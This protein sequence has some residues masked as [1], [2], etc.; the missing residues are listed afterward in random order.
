MGRSLQKPKSHYPDDSP[1][2]IIGLGRS[3]PLFIFALFAAFCG[4]SS[5]AEKPV[6][7]E[8]YTRWTSSRVVGTPDPLPGYQ[9]RRVFPLVEFDEPTGL[10]FYE[11]PG[12][13]AGKEWAFIT[14][15]A[16]QV[17]CM[18]N[19]AGVDRAHLFI[20]LDPTDRPERSWGLPVLAFAVAFDPAFASNRFVYLSYNTKAGLPKAVNRVSR[21]KLREL[22]P[23]RIEREDE[24][25]ILEWHTDG[26][27]GCDLK[28]GPDGM[29]YISSGDGTSTVDE[30]NTGQDASD[31]LSGIL[32]IDV[33]R[34]EDGKRYAVPKDNPFVGLP[35]VR[36]ELWAYGV[37]N[38]WKMSFDRKTGDLWVGDNGQDLWE[39]AYRIEKG[40]N[41][42]WSVF[43]GGHPHRPA[44]KIGGPTPRWTLPTIVQPHTEM[45]S[46]TGG[47]VY[48]GTRL[49]ELKGVYVYGDYATG[50][51]WGARPGSGSRQEAAGRRPD[52]EQKAQS[53]PIPVGGL[54]APKLA[55]HQRLAD[56]RRSVI[57]FGEDKAGEL[58]VLTFDGKISVIEKAPPPLAELAQRTFPRKLSETGLF[59]STMDHTVAAGVIPYDV[60]SPLWSDGAEKLRFL[61]LPAGSQGKVRIDWDGRLDLPNETVLVKTFLLG[62][63]RLET[64]LLHRDRGEWRFYTYVWNDEQTDA[65]LLGEGGL[66]RKYT[67]ADPAAPDGQREQL[68]HFPSRTECMMCH[69]RQ[70]NFTLGLTTYQLNREVSYDRAREAEPGVRLKV[71][72]GSVTDN[73]LRTFAHLGLFSNP[74][75]DLAAVPRHA[76]PYDESADLAARA[77]SYLHVNCAH[78][79]QRDGG[80]ARADLQLLTW[81][82]PQETGLLNG[83]PEEGALGLNDPRIIVPGDP[84][85]SLLLYRMGLRGEGQ[86]PKVGTLRVDEK[87]VAMI[88]RWI[89]SMPR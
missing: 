36:G 79:H 28:F 12:V 62:D 74:P 65:D 58:Y 57:A 55:W 40:A 53:P 73:Q 10:T 31:L 76:N 38:P 50:M 54:P 17:W 23:P 44:R 13:E 9:L 80:G 69:T 41:Y 43:E 61:A 35:T 26:H 25:V 86:M 46:L 47:Y 52:K 11:I 2:L 30:W 29:L 85:R 16:G 24:E 81:L 72:A 78:C 49:P 56:T 45:R 66:D 19:E 37:R 21:F 32:R 34:R 27:N 5:A 75:K 4:D 22:D 14:E 84:A 60:N 88:R 68:W 7:I 64:R 15:R 51:V 83:K 70:S 8:K 77:R 48:H 3:L 1:S 71:T 87:A 82:K 39:M 89:A 42:G 67:V 20:D 18:R 6:G 59:A 33:N 63:R